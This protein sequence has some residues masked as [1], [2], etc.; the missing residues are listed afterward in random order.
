MVIHTYI[1]MVGAWLHI[2]TYIAYRL[3]IHMLFLA[4]HIHT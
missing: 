1:Y 4:I 3:H 2:H